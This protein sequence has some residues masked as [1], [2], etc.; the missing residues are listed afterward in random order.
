VLSPTPGREEDARYWLAALSVNRAIMHAI[1]ASE[2]PCPTDRQ[3]PA[4][5]RS[6]DSH[7]HLRTGE[8]EPPTG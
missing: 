6:R 7:S 2:P 5:I 4:S 1:D 8:S 3:L